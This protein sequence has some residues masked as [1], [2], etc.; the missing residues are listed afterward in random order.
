LTSNGFI[1][2]LID[3]DVCDYLLFGICVMAKLRCYSAIGLSL[4]IALLIGYVAYFAQ[5]A[6]SQMAA[7]EF[8]QHLTNGEF[9]PA[10]AAAQK[11][12]AAQQTAAVARISAAQLK[13]GSPS[14]AIRS[15]MLIEDDQRRADQLANIRQQPG[16][17]GGPQ[18]DFDSLINLITSTVQPTTW[19]Q[20]GGQGDLFGFEGGVYCDPQG[21]LLRRT[22]LDPQRELQRL[23]EESREP[24]K[25]GSVKFP[26]P[27]RKVSLRR[28]EL[29]VQQALALGQTLPDD[30]RYLAGLQKIQYI[31]VYPEE[32]DI[33]IAGPAE[34]WITDPEGRQIGEKS[35]APVLQL[36][37]L[38]VILRH[39]TSKP[40]AIFG[41]S[42][43]PTQDRLAATQEFLNKTTQKPL[44]PTERE[45]WLLQLREQL[46]QQRI[47]INGLDPQSRAAL[48]LVEADYRMKL[49]GVGLEPALPGVENYLDS[50]KVGAGQAPPPLD[51]LRWWFAM[52][53]D[54]VRSSA[55]K[56]AFE[57]RGQGVQVL[58]ENELLAL[59]GERQ[60]TGQASELNSAFTTSFTKHFP[61]LA[62]KYPVYAELRNL[63]DMAM[64]GAI[65][66]TYDLSQ[67]V[68]WQMTCFG[69]GGTYSPKQAV[70]PRWVDSV[71]RSRVINQKHIIVG[72]SGGVRV[73]PWE[74]VTPTALEIDQTARMKSGRNYAN[75][76][77]PTNRDQWWWD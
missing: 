29:A 58:S 39:M 61:Q 76:T 57:L 56:L 3:S 1:P 13:A 55:D 24:A 73:D 68:N 74:Q 64:L 22:E 20:N 67:Q 4:G 77:R 5:A 75:Q 32:R 43:T 48:V 9:A 36:D 33:V 46:G 49:V 11:L 50:I 27:L 14:A 6:E 69:N 19:K 70:A 26:S 45:N 60:H 52:K 16:A 37:D 53:Y 21:T 40:R 28:L 71:M 8:E 15:A 44:K 35:K 2:D 59:N 34:G 38:V 72:V 54:A 66:Q 51:V 10:L 42:I 65:I 31:L 47:D 12:P 18:A 63:F 17:K 30:V 7:Q 23:R 25:V 41:C 62:T